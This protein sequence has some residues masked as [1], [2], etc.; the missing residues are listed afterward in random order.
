MVLNVPLFFFSMAL[1]N[2][3]G[4]CFP[5]VP[6]D[7]A[8]PRAIPVSELDTE[9]TKAYDG[10]LSL[11]QKMHASDGTELQKE[12]SRLSLAVQQVKK[13][14]GISDKGMNANDIATYGD[15][16]RVAMSARRQLRD[17]LQGSE[18]FK[19]R[20]VSSAVAKLLEDAYRDIVEKYRREVE[21]NQS[22]ELRLRLLHARQAT[23]A[24]KDEEK[25]KT[26]EKKIPKNGNGLNGEILAA[27]NAETEIE[28][29]VF[30]QP[31]HGFLD[32]DVLAE[33]KGVELSST[34]LR[35]LAEGEKHRLLLVLTE[36]DP[37]LNLERNLHDFFQRSSVP[38]ASD[39]SRRSTVVTGIVQDGSRRSLMKKELQKD[40]DTGVQADSAFVESGVLQ[41]HTLNQLLKPNLLR[42]VEE[43]FIGDPRTLDRRTLVDLC[44]RDGSL[45]RALRNHFG[46][47]KAFEGDEHRFRHLMDQGIPNLDPIRASLADI[48]QSPGSFTHHAD[49]V[50]LAHTREDLSGDPDVARRAVRYAESVLK[51]KGVLIL[52]ASDSTMSYGA[53]GARFGQY[54]HRLKDSLEPHRVLLERNGL[55]TRAMHP[56]LHVKAHTPQG[57]EA[58]AEMFQAMIPGGHARSVSERMIHLKK[59]LQENDGI[60]TYGMQIMAAYKS[61]VPSA[62]V[63]RAVELPASIRLSEPSKKVPAPIRR[64]SAEPSTPASAEKQDELKPLSKALIELEPHEILKY[65]QAIGSSHDQETTAKQLGI[66]WN[67]FNLWRDSNLSLVA[68]DK[69]LRSIAKANVLPTGVRIDEPVL[70]LVIRVL[71][72]SHADE[73]EFKRFLRQIGLYQRYKNVFMPK[74]PR[75]EEQEE[76]EFEPPAETFVAPTPKPVL[77]KKKKKK[78]QEEVPVA[79]SLQQATDELSFPETPTGIVLRSRQALIDA[80]LTGSLSKSET[81]L[82]MRS[83]FIEGFRR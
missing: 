6:N 11:V 43:H 4:R 2:Y 55:E 62:S 73:A 21:Q 17:S 8:L 61:K 20:R 38:F 59:I 40:S 51:Q 64:V 49:A 80:M 58:M 36:S 45:C 53:A 35:D 71:Q 47:M 28:H 12:R 18:R 57:R 13:K 31:L 76:E 7:E 39:I 66:P 46:S 68:S 77:R 19:D 48:L 15:L 79:P 56:M 50:L 22:Q 1:E 32:L 24:L 72:K 23:S 9:I 52:A 78:V 75:I 30:P 26:V 74:Q 54:A 27:L 41:Q 29:G 3:E 37:L 34:W 10:A 60:L 65:V 14:I 67:T 16:R 33:K 82:S 70:R 25:P 81:A 5:D 44:A 42:I 63:P 69:V 83:A